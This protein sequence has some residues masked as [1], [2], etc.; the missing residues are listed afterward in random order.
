MKNRMSRQTPWLRTQRLGES[1]KR[2]TLHELF[3]RSVNKIALSANDDKAVFQMQK[4]SQTQWL[5]ISKNIKEDK[6]S[7]QIQKEVKPID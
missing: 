1:L 7:L 5:T 4:Q 6:W 3:T 2:E